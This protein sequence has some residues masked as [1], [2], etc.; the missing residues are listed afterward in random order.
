[1]EQAMKNLKAV[2]NLLDKLESMANPNLRFFQMGD[3]SAV[4]LG[5]D[6]VYAGV[7]DI[8][9]DVESFPAHVIENAASSE[10]PAEF[11]DLIYAMKS[12]Q[13]T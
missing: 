4:Y 1:V 6:Q 5:V 10:Y 9:R 12:H 2:L 7:N 11:R 8:L 13:D 3:G